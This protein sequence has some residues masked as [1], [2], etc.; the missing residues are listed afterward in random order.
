MDTLLSSAQMLDINPT[1]SSQLDTLHNKMFLFF[2]KFSKIIFFS[3]TGIEL[4]YQVHNINFSQIIKSWNFK[5]KHLL[6]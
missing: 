3:R 5:D 1:N 4:K 2:L 6:P